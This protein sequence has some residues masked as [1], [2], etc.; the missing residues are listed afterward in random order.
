MKYGKSL[1]LARRPG[2]ESAYVDYNQL[3]AILEQ[4]EE[5]WSHVQMT[6]WSEEYEEDEDDIGPDFHAQDGS[7]WIQ[8]FRASPRRSNPF[9]P[10]PLH[11]SR[12][13]SPANVPPNTATHPSLHH[14]PNR[15]AS[16]SNPTVPHPNPSDSYT[17]R[18][19]QRLSVVFRLNHNPHP[20]SRQPLSPF[21]KAA[22][23]KVR[24][25]AERFLGLLQ[26]E[27]EKVSL[28]ALSRVGELSDT[29]GSL[30][31]G[32]G[33]MSL[34]DTE[35]HLH[36]PNTESEQSDNDSNN[37]SPS[38]D[39]DNASSSDDDD[40][41]SPLNARSS[42]SPV[43]APLDSKSSLPFHHHLQSHLPPSTTASEK[44]AN[45][46]RPMFSD[47]FLG[48]ESILVSAVDEADSYTLIGTE[49]LHL[50]R[51][52]CVNAMAARKILK[53]H[54]K[55]L[56]NRMMGS[57]YS[58]KN[59]L[60]NPNEMSRT[61]S[62]ASLPIYQPPQQ[63]QNHSHPHTPALHTHNHPI[64]PTRAATFSK[65]TSDNV[66]HRLSGT[67]D[68]HLR[69]L[70]NS[71]G[72]SAISASL[73]AA[74]I[75]FETAHYRAEEITRQT[76]ERVEQGTAGYQSLKFESIHSS[77]TSPP[78][79]S[80]E[81][82]QHLNLPVRRLRNVVE[83]IRTVRVVADVAY[84][85]FE[86]FLSRRALTITGSKLGDLGGQSLSALSFMLK[87]D[88]TTA[89]TQP[90]QFILED[91]IEYTDSKTNQKFISMFQD[92]IN[93]I[94]N[95]ASI[96]LYTT[97]YYI[98]SPTS[99]SY[100]ELLK[101]PD[102]SFGGALVGASSSSAFLAAFLYSVWMLHGNF[103][104]ALSFSAFC[105]IVGNV[106]YS[107]ALTNESLQT[108]Y[109]GR[110]LVG[111]GS[112]EVCNRLFITNTSTKSNLTS[113][114]ARFVAASAVGM[115]AGPFIASLLDAFAGRDVEVDV[116]ILGGLIFNHVTGPGWVMAAAWIIQL[117][118]LLFYFKEPKLITK[119]DE[120]EEPPDSSPSNFKPP[121]INNDDLLEP[122]P[123]SPAPSSPSTTP[124]HSSNSLRQMDD[125]AATL[126]PNILEGLNPAV[127][128]S[129]SQ[130]QDEEEKQKL[131]G[132]IS[133]DN[134]YGATHGSNETENVEDPPPSFKF[135][136]PYFL[137][138]AILS[139]LKALS[140]K[141]ATSIRDYR[142]LILSNHAFPVTLLLFGLIE[143]TDEILINSVSLITRRY[144][145]W[146]GASAGLFIA[147]LGIFVL[148]ANFVVDKLSK[149]HDERNLA[150]FFLYFC[151]VG[152][153][154]AVN[155]EAL[156][157]FPN[158]LEHS[159]NINIGDISSP[160]ADH[161][162]I[163]KKVHVYDNPFGLYQ[164]IVGVTWLFMGTIMLEGV[165]TS[166][167]AKSCP[168]KLNNT[169]INAGFLAT[170]VG[171]AGRVMA[172]GFIVGAGYMHSRD[173]LDF[174]NSVFLQVLIFI[175]LSI[176]LVHRSFYHLL[177]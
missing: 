34:E 99:N 105:P 65:Q 93:E 7:D 157:G 140:T 95:L 153:V 57:Y 47:H 66:S 92:T 161:P 74:L 117:F 19:F 52:I 96:F 18:Q 115:S 81:T 139:D 137:S 82:S 154:I 53:K 90:A 9:P 36:F 108:A 127:Q 160:D 106:L 110:L 144:F 116:G 14:H 98:I 1:R 120:E 69:T 171:T 152:V 64:S 176:W 3:K 70:C 56:S 33:L 141:T 13:P 79:A 103:K 158:H 40:S 12:T 5:I 45:T 22:D 8:T 170:L 100:A 63:P 150:R 25:L 35:S 32:D 167:M 109:V 72:I 4:I 114:C 26:S 28:F 113:A 128:E 23:L 156:F 46:L 163:S 55:L 24:H 27:I 89:P 38:S 50:L 11:G 94:I 42:P 130:S 39:D 67:A 124:R 78:K 136:L 162:V 138:P 168:S 177:H 17:A 76:A 61:S 134:S 173:G 91:M 143:L 44:G 159:V 133:D 145:R 174:V 155:F 121:T 60:Q 86:A 51:F 142:A 123:T 58:R 101:A 2:W 41:L 125:S 104:S 77:H 102:S 71:A 31:F 165:V 135:R 87:Y 147:G 16:Q 20:N 75:E 146:H 84:H 151:F 80:R 21:H 149:T 43:V 30:R 15:P 62:Q 54:D 126:T 107:Y 164:Y 132:Y 48:E 10:A 148:P 97:N 68:A 112:C 119:Q 29:V 6:Q 122:L 73:T 111:L 166:L 172:D 49:L 169:F 59:K 83:S 129:Q 175:S 131:L 85:P 118:M 37:S 88:P